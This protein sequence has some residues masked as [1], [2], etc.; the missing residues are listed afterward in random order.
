MITYSSFTMLRIFNKKKIKKI[1]T[2]FNETT[3]NCH[4][5][6]SVINQLNNNIEQLTTNVYVLN[7]EKNNVKFRNFKFQSSVYIILLHNVPFIAKDTYI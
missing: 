5:D 4:N 7:L 1:W 2:C 3:I 6:I